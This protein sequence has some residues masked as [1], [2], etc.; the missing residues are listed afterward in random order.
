MVDLTKRVSSEAIAVLE[1]ILAQLK[2]RSSDQKES[3]L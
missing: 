2:Q 1:E 3:Q